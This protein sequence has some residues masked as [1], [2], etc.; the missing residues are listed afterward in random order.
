MCFS[1]MHLLF[2]DALSLSIR[3]DF[4]RSIKGLNLKFLGKFL[5]ARNL[6]L[7][8]IN[9][10]RNL[11]FL[12]LRVQKKCLSCLPHGFGNLCENDGIR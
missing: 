2:C 9:Y 8:G 6:N 11:R 5:K 4:N 1:C 12:L 3:S 7:R 10:E